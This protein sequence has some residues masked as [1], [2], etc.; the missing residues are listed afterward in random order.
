MPTLRHRLG[1]T[2]AF[3]LLFSTSPY[4][5]A[6]AAEGLTLMHVGDQESWLLS[7]AGN[8]RDVSG[9]ALSFYGGVDRLAQVIANER[10][11]AI[12][13]SRSVLTLN[14]GDAFLPGARFNASLDTLGSAYLGGQDYYD[15]RA[16]RLIGFDA[17]VFGNHEFD[18]GPTTAASFA[19]ASGTT[20]LSANLDL[21][22]AVNGNSFSALAGGM[23]APSKLITTTAGNKIGLIG[24]TTP[25]LPTISS[26]GSVGLLGYDANASATQNLQ[27]LVPILQAQINDLRTNQ[28]ATTI[29]LM[30]HLQNAANEINTVVPQLAGVDIVLSGG[31]HELMSSPGTA[32]LPGDV[33]AF[34]AY[35]QTVSTA[36]AGQKALVVTSNFGNRYVGRLDVQL[37]SD[38]TVMRDASGTPIVGADTRMIRVSGL[39]TDT[40]KVSG[41]ATVF[42]QVVAP[43]STYVAALNG[44]IVGTSQ[45]A[46]NGARGSAG[47]MPGSFVV[48]V[49][50][51][52][53]NLGNLVADAIL[54]AAGG[55][56][57]VALQNGGGIRASIDAGDISRG[58]TSTTLS[59]ANIVVN[60]PN[61]TP[62][63]LKAL[64]EHGYGG[65]AT[66]PL[67]GA[68][69]RFPQIA[70]MRVVYDT[71][72]V[73]GSRIVSITLDDGTKLVADGLVVAGAPAVTLATIDFLARGGD[74]Y[75]F[76]AL[77][78]SFENGVNYLT[79]GEALDRFVSL[80]T[81]QGGL[82]GVVTAAR[83]GVENVL[84]FQGRQIDAAIAAVPEPQAYALM[85]AGI[86]LIGWAA[87]RKREFGRAA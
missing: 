47:A 8:A 57:R 64:L 4:V 52:E 56:A 62:D 5:A 13:A 17:A 85:L 78:L 42:Q 7:A 39:S 28:G 61:V 83:Y 48:G 21:N 58:E 46:L 68:E 23:V 74:G 19:K 11:T 12:G 34:S 24:A 27:A 33:A 70:G 84:D 72:K 3:A 29:V 80:P 54:S 73:A 44:Q 66:S 30:S 36:T 26:P 75:P 43:V 40:D 65:S 9:N 50:N 10:T 79:Y 53:T 20:Y 25:L 18:L 51:A 22:S 16:M 76:Q 67:G 6:A 31:G 69:G 59:F 15:A 60:V 14:A 2:I 63:K 41:D 1:S 86:A 35:P 77:G 71:S 32:L 87:R 37:G 45:V 55:G 82:G 38:G 81:D 49:R